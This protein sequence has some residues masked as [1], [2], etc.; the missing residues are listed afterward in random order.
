MKKSLLV[1]L[2]MLLA[3]LACKATEPIR[4][5]LFIGDSMTGWLAERLEAY[6]TLNGFEVSTVIWDGSTLP[7][8]VNSGKLPSLIKTHKPDAVFICLGL[9]EILA[10]DMNARMSK[11]V[12]A[13]EQ[14]LEGIPFVWVGPPTWPG[15]STGQAFNDWMKTHIHGTGHYFDSQAL[16][17]PRQSAGNPH[18]TRA[19]CASWMDAVVHWLP[20]ADI[21][22]PASMKQPASG[23]MKRGKVYIYRRMK[24]AL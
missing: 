19:A 12:A 22:F 4:R 11:P 2:L 15:K 8:W 18:P 5:V 9:N 16:K 14:Q 24:Q 1:F 13:L 23:E 20:S 10:K 17:L 7:K 21:G 6:G 3:T